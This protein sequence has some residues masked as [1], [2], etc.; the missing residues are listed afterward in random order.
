M[1]HTRE[2]FMGSGKDNSVV[3]T[4]VRAAIAGKVFIHDENRLFIAPLNNLSAGGF[5]VD[6]LVSIPEGSRVRV[7]I[8]SDSLND[9]V[10]ALGKVVRVETDGR[11]GLAVQF[12]AI[13]KKARDVISK[14]V[15]VA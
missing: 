14:S 5:F 13:S 4:H 12:T 11:R 10:Q 7:V 6:R 8:K 15:D 9:A 2:E 3:R 1:K